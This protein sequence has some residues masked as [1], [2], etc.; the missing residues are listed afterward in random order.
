MRCAQRRRD[1]ADFDSERE[2]DA[3]V[4]EV[5]EV[6]EK[7]GGPLSLGEGSDPAPDAVFVARLRA[8]GLV[9]DRDVAGGLLVR[10]PRRE[11]GIDDDAPDPR[12]E[13]CLAAI[14]LAR[15]QS[16]DK[17]VL[18]RVGAS[19]F[20][21]GDCRSDADVLEV[22]LTVERLKPTDGGGRSH[23]CT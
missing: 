10:R 8:I 1:G 16:A 2:R 15:L 20:V 6:A 21:A 18:Y 17:R 3:A 14:A 12:L 23:S 19:R 13:R 11:G 7:D 22:V 5:G 9:V 4:V